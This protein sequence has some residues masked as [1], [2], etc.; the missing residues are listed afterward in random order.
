MY[1]G[2]LYLWLFLER[3]LCRKGKHS[4]YQIIV[5]FFSA[6]LIDS[7]PIFNWLVHLIMIQD[8]KDRVVLD[9]KLLN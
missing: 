4:N 6:V 3:K 1:L 5:I 9:D 2:K 7:R 8:L